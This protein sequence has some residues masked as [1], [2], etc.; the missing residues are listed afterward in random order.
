VEKVLILLPTCAGVFFLITTFFDGFGT[1][2]SRDK[3]L[4]AISF[5]LLAVVWALD[6]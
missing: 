6:W 1:D 2:K 3:L 4:T 5:F